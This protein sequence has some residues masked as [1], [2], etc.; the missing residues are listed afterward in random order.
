MTNKK[1]V[2]LTDAEKV[3]ILSNALDIIAGYEQERI[4][5]EIAGGNNLVDIS[6]HKIVITALK[7]VGKSV[8]HL[9]YQ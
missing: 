4:A 6:S 2:N 8:E 3:E 7:K 5:H 9:R 1:S